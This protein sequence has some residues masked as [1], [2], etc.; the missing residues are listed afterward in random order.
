MARK[1]RG[2]SPHQHAASKG[3]SKTTKRV[4]VAS[5]GVQARLVRVDPDHARELA[6]LIS[7]CE[8]LRQEW[9]RLLT[10]LI[11]RLRQEGCGDC[12]DPC[13]D[14]RGRN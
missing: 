1:G 12:V 7:A 13:P 8:G 5:L 2:R 3:R 6:D 4:T 14:R 9:D 11:D 10:R